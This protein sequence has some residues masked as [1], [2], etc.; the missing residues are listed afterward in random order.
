M[1]KDQLKEFLKDNLK[2]RIKH[3]DSQFGKEIK[4]ELYLDE[5]LITEDDVFI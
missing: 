5:D 3:R 4:V 2:I 1:D